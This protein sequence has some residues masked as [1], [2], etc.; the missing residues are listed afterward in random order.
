MPKR[1]TV[2]VCN[3]ARTQKEKRF[4][5]TRKRNLRIVSPTLKSP[6]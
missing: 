5:S 4:L 1:F 6:Q 3:Y 2:S